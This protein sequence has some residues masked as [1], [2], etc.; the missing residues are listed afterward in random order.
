VFHEAGHIIFS[1]FGVHDG[2]RRIA[3]AIPDSGDR[4][5]RVLRQEEP[6]G[7]AIC[8]WWAGQNLV[9]LAP[10]IADA[11]AL[12]MVLLGGR[13]GAE[14]EGHDW[15]Y[16]L[17]A[18]RHLARDGA[19]HTAHARHDR[20][21][22]GARVRGQ[23][24]LRN[25]GVGFASMIIPAPADLAG[26]YRIIER[27]ALPF[28]GHRPDGSW[29][30]RLKPIAGQMLKQSCKRMS[31]LQER[32]YA[33]DRWSVLLIF[34][35]MD[36]AGKDSTIKH[37]MSGVNP[38]GCDVHAFK[39]PSTEELDHDF[40]VAHEP[41]TAAPRHI[42]IFNARTTRD[43]GRARAPEHPRQTAAAVR[44]RHQEHLARALRGHQRY[45][46][47]LARQGVLVRKFLPVR[48]E[49][50][51]A[52]AVPR[53][54]REAREALE[55]LARRRRRA[56][57]LRD[58][59]DGLRRHDSPHLHRDGAVVRGAC[60]SQVVH[61]AGRV[62]GDHRRD[63]VARSALSRSRPE[64][65]RRVQAVKAQL[66]SEANA[67]AARTRRLRRSEAVLVAGRRRALRPVSRQE[68]G[69]PVTDDRRL[70]EKICLEGFQSGLSWI[71]IL[72]KRENF[73]K[74]FKD[75]DP[76]WSRVSARATCS[77]C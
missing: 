1:P 64:G 70:F 35:A 75:F 56:R 33:Q 65:A 67:K 53:A 27:I 52:Q 37:V 22:R 57:A 18:A 62:G 16:I 32:L 63:S 46:R 26:R 58:L 55:V 48:L 76:A 24:V 45:E 15:E 40:P 9:D 17:D 59:H 69:R 12:R 25:V 72:R 34:Q 71:T 29:G 74:A 4:A 13:T 19:G 6:F 73:R 43:A 2:A 38:Q 41:P 23:D 50:R 31:G 60:R 49:G 14:V 28:E 30:K 20:D 39:A 66:E 36:A 68:W 10:Y 51:A 42:G 54:A 77:A 61:A 7:A 8:A 3:A 21:G 5:V 11:R 47:Y 44:A